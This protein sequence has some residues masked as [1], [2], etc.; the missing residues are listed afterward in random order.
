MIEK[1]ISR[2]GRPLNDVNTA[3]KNVGKLE[4]A[5]LE[6]GLYLLAL[7]AGAAPMLGFLG[8]STG[9][10]A[11]FMIWRMRTILIYNFCLTVFMRQ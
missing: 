3:I 2:L 4:I 9:W 1:G 10:S 6:K 7:S 11:L 5:N 8:T